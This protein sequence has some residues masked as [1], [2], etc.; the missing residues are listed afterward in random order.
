MRDLAFKYANLWT[1]LSI[2]PLGY[3]IQYLC[4]NEN[5]VWTLQILLLCIQLFSI[6]LNLIYRCRF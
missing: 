2:L 5:I 4:I 3:F 6:M 1:V